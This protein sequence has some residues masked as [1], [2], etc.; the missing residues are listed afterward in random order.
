MKTTGKIGQI[1]WV[2][3]SAGMDDKRLDTVFVTKAWNRATLLQVAT[4]L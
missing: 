3:V 2:R 1:L 4:P